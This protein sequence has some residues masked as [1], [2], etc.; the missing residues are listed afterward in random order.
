MD[1]TEMDVDVSAVLLP[2]KF[3]LQKLGLWFEACTNIGRRMRV[4]RFMAIFNI[5]LLIISNVT[6]I[7]IAREKSMVESTL[8]FMY[9]VRQISVF[10]KIL[11][12]RLRVREISA[13]F[14]NAFEKII[15][16]D[17]CNDAFDKYQNDC[18]KKQK[19]VIAVIVFSIITALFWAISIVALANFDRS[20]FSTSSVLSGAT[21][22]PL[23]L[24]VDVDK[25]P[26]L[27]NFL[28]IYQIIGLQPAVIIMMGFFAFYCGALTLSQK[29]FKHLDEVLLL[30]QTPIN[31]DPPFEYA[32]YVRKNQEVKDILRYVVQHHIRSLKYLVAYPF[33]NGNL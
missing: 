11:V 14:T 12:F 26:L 2:G 32:Q 3:F 8:Q 31:K 1:V 22:F 4:L 18:K 17:L 15:V 27:Q 9:L 10:Q 5:S 33:N 23:W 29:M 16:P 6:S 21:V 28:L 30:V 20:Q 25:Y 24:P 19:F 13:L 7:I